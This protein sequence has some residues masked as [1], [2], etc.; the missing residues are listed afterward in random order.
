MRTGRLDV[1]VGIDGFR[2]TLPGPPPAGWTRGVLA[3]VWM[4]VGVGVP[5]AIQGF[6]DIHVV[7]DLLDAPILWMPYLLV[8]SGWMWVWPSFVHWRSRAGAYDVRADRIAVTA[9]GTRLTWEA[10]REVRERD[11]VVELVSVDGDLTFTHLHGDERRWL[12]AHLDELWSARER[13]GRAPAEI[14]RLKEGV[15]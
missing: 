13:G 4:G 8:L 5:V 14:L 7:E 12:V 1:Q 9:R 6:L 3:V 2:A 11:R 15:S 10:V